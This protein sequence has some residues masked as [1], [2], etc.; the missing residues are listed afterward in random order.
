LGRAGARGRSTARQF[1]GQGEVRRPRGE[2]P[3]QVHPAAAPSLKTK[4][5]GSPKELTKG[6]FHFIS[7]SIHNDLPGGHQTA[8][9]N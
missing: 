6:P 7:G 3:E 9:S 4:R 5:K 1:K 8:S 2:A